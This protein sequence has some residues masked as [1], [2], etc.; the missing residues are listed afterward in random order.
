MILGRH[1]QC[2]GLI[3]LLTLGIKETA[4]E[5][6]AQ[7]F[8]LAGELCLSPFSAHLPPSGVHY[9]EDRQRPSLLEKPS[10]RFCKM[11]CE[12]V[13]TVLVVFIVLKTLCLEQHQETSI[14]KG[15]YYEN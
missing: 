5:L 12:E 1:A 4:Q 15:H 6:E 8:S 2:S 7:R 11:F 10:L 13:Q 3:A 14:T 9:R